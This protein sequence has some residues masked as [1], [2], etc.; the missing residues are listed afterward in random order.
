MQISVKKMIC[1]KIEVHEPRI[2]V[3]QIK[4]LNLRN[5][6]LFHK[7]ADKLRTRNLFNEVVKAS[8]VLNQSSADLIIIRVIL[9]DVKNI[10]VDSGYLLYEAS[11][12]SMDAN[13]HHTIWRRINNTKKGMNLLL[14]TNLSIVNKGSK[15][16]FVIKN[17]LQFRLGTKY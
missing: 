17:N 8:L 16:T 4:G 9:I 2:N 10:I 3:N 12:L 13:A 7:Q 11:D 6:N 15:P 1:Y 5:F 14:T